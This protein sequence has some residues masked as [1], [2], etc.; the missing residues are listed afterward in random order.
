MKSVCLN[1]HTNKIMKLLESE[2]YK[3]DLVEALNNIDLKAFENKT[4][5]VTGGLGLIASAIIDVLLMFGKTGKIYV[6]ARDYEQFK[7]RFGG[8]DNISYVPYNALGKAQLEEKIDYIIHGAGLASPELYTSNPVETILSNFDGVHS[9]LEFARN[10]GVKRLLYI[11]SSEVYGE[12]STDESFKEDM[13]GKIDIDNVRESYAVAKRASEMLCRSYYWEYGVDSVVV[14]PGHIYGPS[15]KRT[16]KR[17]SSVFAF[18]AANGELLKM[19][20]SGLQK[21]SY[22]YSVD[23]A[24]QILMVLLMGK[25]NQAY[26]I[27]HDEV[28][29]IRKMAEILAKAGNTRLF[30]TEASEKEKKVF[31]P[32]SNS[33]L[34][35]S[36]VKKLG[37]KDTFSVEEG[38]IH[39]VEIIREMEKE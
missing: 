10:R 8:L 23:C 20:S 21:R 30:L 17:I 6:G 7:K 39:T 5:F 26:N 22:C 19:K 14:R 9:L 32:M 36:K 27:G 38:L 29:T 24:V 12:K 35:N 2:K 25:C 3:N 15:A 13:Y 28:I 31:N 33:S 37:Y 4:F 34:D 1:D 18:N 11:S 16:D